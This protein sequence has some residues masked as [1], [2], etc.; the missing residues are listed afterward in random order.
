MAAYTQ[1]S[2]RQKALQRSAAASAASVTLAQ[3]LYQS[4]LTDFQTV[5]DAQRTMFSQ[6]DKLV[7]SQGQRVL[8]L[9]HLYRAF[10]G[11]WD[12]DS[13]RNTTLSVTPPPTD[14]ALTSK[15]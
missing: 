13:V 6:Q 7:I 8:D 12:P 14:N 11:G 3:S 15:R 1:E 9:I 2:V 5:L 10:G 4:G